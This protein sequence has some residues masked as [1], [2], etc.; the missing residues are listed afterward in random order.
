MLENANDARTLGG[1]LQLVFFGGD[2]ERELLFDER[3]VAGILVGGNAAVGRQAELRAQRAHQLLGVRDGGFRRLGLAID[4]VRIAPQWLPVAAPIKRE[5]PSRQL[6]AGVPLALAEVQQAA[7]REALLQTADEILRVGAL[8]RADGARL[9]F[10]AVH[11]VD[12]HERRLATHAEAHVGAV[13]AR[14]DRIAG[15]ED[16][17]PGVLGVRQRDARALE[18]ALDPHVEGECHLGRLVRA[19]DGRGARRLRRRGERNVTFAGEQAGGGVEPDPAGTGDVDF[20]PGV[21]VGEVGFGAGSA[22]IERLHVGTQ[23]NEV[24]GDEARGKADVTQKSERAASRNRGMS[25]TL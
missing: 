10:I 1:V 8:G 18:H 11:V 20:G 4:E 14:V 9:P 25:R 5:R 16:L 13:E 23:L 12:R 2:V 22:A 7:G 24:A 3:V 21:Q 19:A 17:F 15:G 6:L